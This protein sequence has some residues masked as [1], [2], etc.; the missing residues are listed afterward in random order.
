MVSASLTREQQESRLWALYQ[1]SLDLV[2]DI[3]IDTLLERIA[4]ISCEQVNTRYG[5]VGLLD[6]EGKLERFI[7]I[8][9]TPEQIKKIGHLPRG[10]GLLRAV[11]D[12]TEPI[13]I[14]DLSNDPRLTVSRRITDMRIFLGGSIRP[15]DRLLG[16]I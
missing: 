13:R 6:A 1:A 15:G 14:E 8:G 16:M 9:L 11:M 4:K 10:L 7:P 3:S 2:Q 12:A 5:A